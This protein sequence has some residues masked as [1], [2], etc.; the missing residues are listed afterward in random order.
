MA[1]SIHRH[2]VT[3]PRM[4]AFATAYDDQTPEDA[5]VELVI[6]E[7]LNTLDDEALSALLDQFTAAGTALY[8]PGEGIV[9]DAA[10]METMRQLATGAETLRAAQAERATAA[11]ARETEAAELAA[12]ISPVD[13]TE[14]DP[15]ADPEL[16]PETGAPVADPDAEPGDAPV[17][18][19]E[20]DP[21]TPAEETPEALAASGRRSG[22]SISLPSVR[23]RQ[24]APRPRGSQPA[25]PSMRDFVTMAATVPIHAG[26]QA[27]F[28]VMAASLSRQLGSFPTSQ[29]EQA[30]KRGT[31]L[32]QQFGLATIRKPYD[33]PRLVI[34]ENAG[35]TQVQEALDYAADPSRLPGGVL[36]ASGGWCAPFQTLYELFEIESRDGIYSIPEV[37]VQ[38]AGF[39]FTPGPTFAS[40]FAAVG[41]SYTAAN[42][43]A[44]D[45]GVDADGVGDGSP[46][47]K[48]CYHIECADFDDAE[49]SFDGL[50]LTAGLLQRKAYPELIARVLRGAMIAHDHKM[51]AHRLA[52]VMAGS[53]AVAM[54]ADQVGAVAPILTAIELQVE[55]LRSTHRTMRNMVM[56][57]VLPFWVHGAIR[58]DIS[59]RLATSVFDVNDA[60]IDGW[61]RQRGIVPQFIYGL[62]DIA[63]TAASGFT[64]FPTS[65]DIG[66]YPAGT[67][68]AGGS[69]I[70]T[71]DTVYD[72]TLLG[73][74]D[75]TALF[76]EEGWLVAKRGHDSRKVN[77]PICADG[78][79]HAGVAIDCDGS[80]GA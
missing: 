68:V 33:D 72:S 10:G 4:V 19:P 78:A 12:Q 24:T 28:D 58:A 51:S 57:S 41:F 42:D 3:G 56:E 45:Y 59:R 14:T 35:T 65:V 5:P 13:E 66:I 53:T 60:E 20:A 22:M 52:A 1:P 8:N 54:P 21:E 26:E 7:D 29:Y 70:V 37:N 23:S 2:A 36:T 46:G 77:V 38:R 47:S 11:A 61:F 67:W 18:D 48:P 39:S 71:L 79:T 9:P 34:G 62:D 55:H 27:D 64:Q 40:I 63:T 31:H 80:A 15:E 32:R 25:E 16:D 17:V 49:L 76:S 74:N 50:C 75:F 43:V 44:G 6:P 69:E 30:A 73:T